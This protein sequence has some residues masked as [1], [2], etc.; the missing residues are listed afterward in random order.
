M[1]GIKAILEE[2]SEEDKLVIIQR[3]RDY[4][5]PILEPKN[6][7][8]FKQFVVCLTAFYLQKD[9]NSDSLKQHLKELSSQQGILFSAFLKN[10]I[11]KILEILK[12]IISNKDNLNEEL[13]QEVDKLLG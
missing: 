2:K 11:Q 10:K 8:K 3:I 6:T 5:N 9:L 1:K 13:L 4:Y 7:D 12:E